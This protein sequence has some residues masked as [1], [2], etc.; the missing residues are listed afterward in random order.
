MF[1]T[2]Q[3]VIVISDKGISYEAVVIAVAKSDVG[4]GAYK[5]ALKGSGSEQLGQWHKA[6]DV[7]IQEQTEEQEQASWDT[8]IRS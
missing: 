3:K 8:F 4:L 7:F 1:E 5:V 2:G 6:E